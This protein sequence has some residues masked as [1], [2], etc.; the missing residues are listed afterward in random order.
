LLWPLAVTVPAAL[1]GLWIALTLLVRAWQ[2]HKSAGE[3]A[4]PPK[5]SR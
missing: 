5:N 1:V 3:N 2:L 4:D